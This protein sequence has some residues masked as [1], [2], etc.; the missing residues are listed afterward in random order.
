MLEHRGTNETGGRGL[1]V[2]ERR[3]VL[4]GL[5][6]YV[7]WGLC[8]IYWKLLL[9]V[10]SFEII[11]HRIIWCFAVTLVV[12]AV[13][14]LGFGELVRQRRAWRYLVPSSLL[15][16]VNW[17]LYIYAVNSGNVIETAIGYYINPLVS[18]VLGVVVFR[19]RLTRLQTLAVALCTFGIVFFTVNYGRFPWIALSLAFSFGA[20]GA[21]K[22]KA[23]YAATPALAFESMVMLVPAIVLAI[24]LAQVTG[25]HAFLGDTATAHGWLLTALLVLAGPVTAVPLILFASAANRIPLSLLG[26]I[27]YVSPTIALLSGVFLFGEAFTVAHAVCLG[28]IWAGLA[29]VSAETVAASRKHPGA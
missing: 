23:G 26:F 16:S 6:C 19:E 22:K 15:I 3:G 17:A 13:G 5:F 25:T 27:Q 7:F 4:C 11:A 24:V 14:R 28:C 18:I 29:I 21:V 2:E 12:C 9:E 1:S 20:Y 10:N 8:P